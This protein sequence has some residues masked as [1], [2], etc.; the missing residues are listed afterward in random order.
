MPLGL[1]KL[2]ERRESVTAHAPPSKV[3][4]YATD[5]SRLFQWLYDL[6]DDEVVID[7]STAE[8]RCRSGE[9]F[10]VRLRE[11]YWT[12][13][14]VEKSWNDCSIKFLQVEAPGLVR[15]AVKKREYTVELQEQVDGTR[16]RLL[17]RPD[18]TEPDTLWDWLAIP[19]AVIGL[20]LILLT[21][22]ER[23]VK[24]ALGRHSEAPTLTR[25]KRAV[26]S[27]SYR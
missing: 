12:G 20:P 8:S 25:L 21:V 14:T 5:V 9:T 2:D 27:G 26:E 4:M 19:L 16:I 11:E 7:T 24:K 17:D 23:A 10:E 3:F 22:L 18:P 15:F 6:G 13:A 1:E